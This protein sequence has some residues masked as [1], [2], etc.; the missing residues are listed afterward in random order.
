MP[1]PK[2]QYSQ[3]TQQLISDAVV[4]LL[5]AEPYSFSEEDVQQLKQVLVSKNDLYIQ[6]VTADSNAPSPSRFGLLRLQDGLVLVDH[7]M[8]FKHEKNGSAVIQVNKG[9]NLTTGEAVIVKQTLNS[10]NGSPY[11]GE[12]QALLYLAEKSFSNKSYGMISTKRLAGG[13]YRHFVVTRYME[14]VSLDCTEPPVPLDAY[15]VSVIMRQLFA[16]VSAFE[17]AGIIHRD[18]NPGN[19]IWQQSEKLLRPVDFDVTVSKESDFFHKD[20]NSYINHTEGR[21]VIGTPEFAIAGIDKPPY[22]YNRNTE[23]YAATKTLIFYLNQHC[24]AIKQQVEPLIKLLEDECEYIKN[25]QQQ[26]IAAYKKDKKL[27]NA[28]DYLYEPSRFLDIEMAFKLLALP[29]ETAGSSLEAD[30]QSANEVNVNALIQNANSYLLVAIK[31]IESQLLAAD[32]D[33]PNK[34]AL[35]A[36]RNHVE[37]ELENQDATWKQFNINIQKFKEVGERLQPEVPQEK[38]GFFSSIFHGFLDA[39]ARLVKRGNSAAPAKTL[40]KPKL[41]SAATD[42][43]TRLAT[44]IVDLQ[45]GYSSTSHSRL[46]RQ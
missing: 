45:E 9:L 41:F 4:G 43:F 44:I 37:Q 7:K 36:L 42:R 23:W 15:A 1:D 14:G 38:R 2:M 5:H 24:A 22:L 40:Q 25:L 31:V 26:L 3:S 30:V 8:Q 20:Y 10:S 17:K 18:I 35:N 19:L 13:Y 46:R 32:A 11:N 29:R 6:D 39:L 33:S 21:A 27:S 34:T 16:R 28:P 12:H